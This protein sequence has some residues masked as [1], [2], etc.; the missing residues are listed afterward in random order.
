MSNVLQFA[1]HAFRA[2]NAV[3]VFQV[4]F[5]KMENVY[6]TQYNGFHIGNVMQNGVS[7]NLVE[8][9]GARYAA[10]VTH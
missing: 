5:F 3:H 9:H 1:N 6:R 10:V 7:N 8:I 4:L 2:I